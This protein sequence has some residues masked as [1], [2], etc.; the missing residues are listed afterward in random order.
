[1]KNGVSKY[2][3]LAF[4][5]LHFSGYAQREANIWYFGTYAGIDFNSG[6]PIPLTDGQI[7]RWEGVASMCDSLGNL[8]M[9]TDGDSVWNSQH[10]H[11]PNGYDLLGDPGSTESAIIVP[12]PTKDSLYLIFTV[13]E[14]G[15][16]DGLCYSIVNM[17][18]N[19]GLGDIENKNIQLETP[20]SEKITAVRHANN[21]DFW[22]IS[23]GWETDSFFVHLVTSDGI[24]LMPQIY[25]LGTPHLDIGLSGNN[26]VGYMKVSPD[27]SKIACVLQVNRIVEL[28]DFN[29]ETGEITNPVTITVDE[30]PYGVEFSPEVTKLYFTSRFSLY[31]VDLSNPE[32]DSIINSV[33]F[34]DSSQTNN[35]FGSVQLATDGKIYLAHEFCDFLG[36]VNN[37]A[38]K[39]DTCGFILDG[40]FLNE[41]QSR[42]GLPDFVQ[43]YFLPPDFSVE[44]YCFGDSS[45]FLISDT[46]GIDSVFWNF[47]DFSSI[48]NTSHLF[49]PKHKY[50]ETGVY[51]VLLTMWR[52]GTEYLKERI[53]QINSL[54][55][56]NL[57]VDTTICEGSSIL[58]DAT[59]INCGYLWHDFSTDS[60]YWAN[61]NLL[62]SVLV[63]NLYTFCSKQDTISV[64][65]S[66][67]PEFDLGNDTGF[68]SLDSLKLEIDFQ[69]VD[70]LWNTGSYDSVIFASIP[71]SYSLQ[72]I[73]S[74]SCVF[75]DTINVEQYPLPEFSIG[76]DTIICPNSS[77]FL[78]NDD[79]QS[80]LW[81]DSSNFEILE[82]TNSGIFWLEVTDTNNCKY[83]DSIS[84][85]A[86]DVPEINLGKD[87]LICEGD[88]VK[89]QLKTQS[90]DYLWSDG[91]TSNNLL[92]SDSGL[93]WVEVTN[94][95]GT[96]KD[97]IYLSTEYCGDI[98]IPNIFTPN[99][100]G[101]NDFFKIKGIEKEAWTIYIYDRLGSLV[102]FS[103]N[104]KS[105]WQAEGYPEATY[106]FILHHS[107]NK[108]NLFKGF[109][110]VYRGN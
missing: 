77:I 1:M 15:G 75:S 28:Y 2:L 12:Y 59:C 109:V 70:F 26:A 20:V 54:P 4:L 102:F 76:N 73:D 60:I 11:M 89:L 43:T 8:L 3:F 9:Y 5:F 96:S 91:S 38:K 14:E 69:N 104:Y 33:T 63:V 71:G 41:R 6:T 90:L 86:I 68:C 95:C 35:F 82:L 40:F 92:V 67:L 18:L 32:P 52:N 30:S 19:N 78:I 22:V 45:L 83:R 48:D 50:T 79:F 80:Y 61:E 56:V 108:N 81:S 85:V 105:D 93:Y 100:D 23:H 106:F 72:L 51:V 16:D 10:E 99:N 36:V 27:G 29:N 103:D 66:P 47:G 13:D 74:L 44:N 97:E 94:I 21:R 64:N 49:S 110:E 34:I 25:E 7:N 62:Y 37:P 58:L 53:I 101:I 98:Y 84:V 57:G 42:M 24:N 46:V 55:D 88:F 87:T 39:G 65:M 17:N 107:T 31:Q